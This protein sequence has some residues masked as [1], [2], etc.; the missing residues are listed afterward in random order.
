MTKP[1]LSRDELLQRHDQLEGEMAELR[2]QAAAIDAAIRHKRR[3]I[4]AFVEEHGDVRVV[5]R[6]IL[7]RREQWLADEPRRAVMRE[8]PEWQEWRRRFRDEQQRISERLRAR[9]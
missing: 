3:E 5:V 4:D 2:K 9:S 7:E 1:R 6:T 8:T